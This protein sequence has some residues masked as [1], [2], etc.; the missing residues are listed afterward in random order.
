MVSL[1]Q[2]I[3]FIKVASE[4]EAI[5]LEAKLVRKYLPKFNIQLKD[6]KSPLYIEI[7]DSPYPTVL[8]KRKTDLLKDKLVYGP[9]ASAFEVKSLLY[10]I[11][12]IFPYATHLPTKRGCIYSQIG[13]CNP[14]PSV[15]EQES[16]KKFKTVLAREYKKITKGVVKILSGKLGLLQKN[17]LREMIQLSKIQ[18]YE[19]AS[20]I[21]KKL[22][23]LVRLTQKQR[24]VGQYVDNPNLLAEIRKGELRSLK[25]VISEKGKIASLTRIECFDVAHL[26]G[27]HPT[28]SM[29]TMLDGSLEKKY[30]R[31]FKILTKLKGDTDR[32]GEVIKRRLKHLDDWGNPD[33]IIVDGGKPQVAAAEKVLLG[34]IPVVGIAKREE[35]LVMHTSEGFVEKKLTG[36]SLHLVQR[37]RNEAHRFARILHHRQVS[38]MFDNKSR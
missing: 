33:L 32:M 26:A 4:F 31:H 18:D 12:K 3:R 29:V 24:E 34:K 9:F 23:M 14:C 11:R 36:P 27:T 17:L 20:L 15:I 37:I 21:K 35:K 8:L 30:Y 7:S 25:K 22:D 38:K 6:D 19:K 1:A 5:T 13:L 2:K 28:A 10:E 16:S